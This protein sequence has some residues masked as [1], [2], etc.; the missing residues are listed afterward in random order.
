MFLVLLLSFPSCRLVKANCISC[1]FLFCLFVYFFGCSLILIRFW[2]GPLSQ[3]ARTRS[4]L[5]CTLRRLTTCIYTTGNTP[6]HHRLHPPGKKNPKTIKVKENRGM[7]MSTFRVSVL[8]EIGIPQ[9]RKFLRSQ[10]WSRRIVLCFLGL[11]VR[12]A[13]NVFFFPAIPPLMPPGV[14]ESNSRLQCSV[15]VCVGEKGIIT[16]CASGPVYSWFK[17]PLISG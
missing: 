1:F 2:R 12:G 14:Q 5:Q 6:M 17:G 13:Q 9:C 8:F 7:K 15:C 3:T 4:R 16:V 11:S 10:L